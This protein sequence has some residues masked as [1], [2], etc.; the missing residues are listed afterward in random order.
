MT[1]LYFAFGSNMLS[2]RLLGCCPSAKVVRTGVAH[3]SSLA[4]FEGE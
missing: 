1:S 2:A 3:A 4:F